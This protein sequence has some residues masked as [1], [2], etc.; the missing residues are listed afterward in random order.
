MPGGKYVRAIV[1]PDE[2]CSVRGD[3]SEEEYIDS[4][5]E[6][7][8][9]QPGPSKLSSKYDENFGSRSTQQTVAEHSHRN[10]LDRL[11]RMEQTVYRMSDQR[12]EHQSGV[13]AAQQWLGERGIQ[14]QQSNDSEAHLP[15][16][17]TDNTGGVRWD[18]RPF[19]Q[20]IPTSKLWV[21]WY[22]FKSNLEIAVDL[23]NVSDG[24]RAKL[25]YLMMGDQLQGLVTAAKLCPSFKDPRCYSALM[26]NVGTYLRSLVDT[27]AEHEEFTRLKQESNESILQG[28]SNRDV[29]NTARTYN[30][31][32]QLI[33]QAA[34]R[35]EAF[36]IYAGPPTVE[37]ERMEVRTAS[38]QQRS[39]PKRSSSE[40]NTQQR[41]RGYD[42]YKRSNRGGTQVG[43]RNRCFRCNRLKHDGRECPAIY[44]NC[45][46]CNQRGHF[47]VTCR[48]KNLN[49][50]DFPECADEHVNAVK[51][52]NSLSLT[53]V[54]FDCRVGLSEPISF[55]IDSGAD[56]NVI[57]G[58]DWKCLEP[59]W[60]DRSVN[61]EFV[62]FFEHP[63][64]RAYAA[65]QPMVVSKVFWA[66]VEVS[67]LCKPVVRAKFLVVSKGRRSLLGR[68]TA[69]DLKLLQVGEA[70]NS[71][72]LDDTVRTFPKIPGI[73]IKFSIDRSV[74]PVRNAY[75][76]VPAAFRE[77]ARLR[78]D[79]MEAQGII[80]KVTTAP[81]WISGMSAVP[82][83][84]DDFRLVVNMRAPNKAIKREYFRMPMLNEMKSKLHGAKY[85]SKLDLSSAYYHLELSQ[86]SRELTTFLSE[87]GMY[88][89]TRLMFGVNCAPEIFQ[90]EMSR[91]LEGI[92]NVIVYIDDILMFADTLETLRKTVARVLKVLRENNLT[93][94]TAKCQFD[95]ERIK[96]LG[97]EL[98]K[99]GFHVDEV[100]VAHIRNFREP[101]TT[102]E[103][104]NFLGLASF[105]SPYIKNFADLTN[106]LWQ[107]AT[108]H[109]W[110]WGPDQAKAFEKTKGKIASCTVALGYFSE[111]D[112]TVLYTDASPNALGAV[113][114]Q[115]GR[116]GTR[117]VISFAS[118]AL[119]ISEKKYA[120]NQRVAL[121][122]VWAVEHFSFFL[123]GR[124]FVLRT[125]ARGV[126][127]ILNRYRE[128]SKRAL[129]RANGWALRL[130][131]YNYKVEFIRGRENI[132]DPSFRLC[133]V[134]PDE[135]FDENSSP[136]ELAA[137]EANSVDFV[138]EGEI[139]SG[140]W[141]GHLNWF[142][143]VKDELYL[144]NG[145]VLKGGRVVIPES[146]REK[147]LRVAHEGHPLT[148]K[149]KAILRERVWW[150][151]MPGD[152]EKWVK[153][154][155]H[156]AVNGRPEKPSPM[157]RTV[158]PR[159]AWETI[160]LDFNGPYVKFG[161][162]YI[163][164]IVDYRSRYLI[165]RP[166]KSTS[167]E[168]TK[169]VLEEIFD[170][171]GFPESM[172]SDNGPPF[173]GEDYKQYCH[174]RGIK[175]IFSTPF[176][177][178][179]NG[180]V[181][182]YMKVINKS[183]AIAVSTGSDYNEELQAAIRAHNSASHT[184]TK[185]PPE[186]I[187]R[188]RR[189]KRGLPLF[190]RGQTNHDDD[191]LNK[192]DREMK[193]KA[194]EREDIRSGA[195]KCQL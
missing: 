142:R 68:E 53:D 148:A 114:T 51:S 121:G 174:E 94:N 24:N 137:L 156:C 108:A 12:H 29:A 172:K 182:N 181:E 21:E 8:E 31:D 95:Q 130:S 102:S 40:W 30:H 122:S 43:R 52:I 92:E 185:V 146:L 38:S 60:D 191:A 72:E 157:K 150:P 124:H 101:S 76:N 175:T 13:T 170:K 27:T 89:F 155:Q 46:T 63:D 54:L 190:D 158:V 194:K 26:Q 111:D 32:T 118:K 91:I 50:L 152:A 119:T 66:N 140:E 144:K 16:T 88:R 59:Q 34:T 86:E 25:L 99:D 195:R 112:T 57:G 167:F 184:V 127:F 78:L 77:A 96:F 36:G 23:N 110:Q 81:E 90:R 5:E 58:N 115:E 70:V 126:S 149:L 79:D 131:P 6:T 18:I 67:G 154:C 82:K 187:M 47:S 55:L 188:G 180:L 106:P 2:N 42:R 9:P 129:T 117:R 147:T 69:S 161:G 193:L 93:L 10:L 125:D 75:F 136:W 120:Q 49:N 169:R 17:K 48:K 107:V 97:H 135:P 176:F 123:L 73:K 132:A 56:A 168:V 22:R 15:S 61:L 4:E 28:M 44:K 166:V 138:T 164:V 159:T 71:S 173:N 192:R 14:G 141:P 128:N 116:D 3:F 7:Q 105:V 186:E 45:N 65:D 163:L 189:I 178:Q 165:A 98:N 1:D 103:L 113:L 19:P 20:G 160:A 151:G 139:Q 100:K 83:G 33:V 85:F 143:S 62:D 41:G 84:R 11:E 162:I 80:E 153:S 37:D 74:P 171:E 179:Q 109:T 64:L 104:H 145:I 39:T 133:H 177:P 134:M 183:M 35:A 87:T